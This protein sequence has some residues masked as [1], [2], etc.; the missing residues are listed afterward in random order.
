MKKFTLSKMKKLR[1]GKPVRFAVHFS[2]LM[3]AG[4]LMLSA[5]SF[6]QTHRYVK[7]GGTGDGSS[8]AEAANLAD[9]LEQAER[10]DVIHL[11]SGTHIPSKLI[12]GGDPEKPGDVTF[13]IAANISIVGGY[14]AEPEAGDEPDPATHASI[15]SGKLDNENHAVHVVTVTAPK[16][17]DHQVVISGIHI[18]DGFADAAASNVEVNGVNF[19]RDHGGGLIIGGASVVMTDCNI[20]NNRSGRM[21]A[22]MYVFGGSNLVMERCTIQNN[23]GVNTNSN[24]AGLFLN[25]TVAYLNNTYIIHN[26]AGGVAAGLQTFNGTEIYMT[27]S[28]I[29]Y[30]TSRTHGGGFYHRNN[31]TG[32]MINCL[33]YGNSNNGNGPG[34]CAHDNT[35]LDIISSTITNNSTTTNGGG[36]FTNAGTTFN[37]Y[38]S[39]V[40]GNIQGETSSDATGTGTFSFASSIR[41]EIV[42]DADQDTIP[43]LTFVPSEMLEKLSEYVVLPVGEDNPA[44]THG[45][46]VEELITLG[47]SLELD[48]EPAILA[49]DQLGNPREEFPYM[50]AFVDVVDETVYFYVKVDGAGNGSSWESPT[51]LTDALNRVN[52]G[53]VIHI[54]AGTYVPENTI[55]GGNPEDSGDITI[56]ISSNITMI[57]GYPANATEGAESDPEEHKT[58]LS[59]KLGEELHAYHVVTVT[60]PRLE[61]HKVV[62]E[63]IH[64]IEGFA[65][66]T[67]S[68]VEINGLN[69][70][71]DHG[72]GMLIGNAHIE[73]VNVTVEDNR[74]GRHAAGIYIFGESH[75]IMERCT[76]QNNV[77][78]NTTS[79]AAGMFMNNTVAHINETYF[80]YNEAGGVAAGLQT[81][82]GSE[83]YLTNS[84][85]ANNKSRT[86]G[87]GF[88]HR[89]N[90]VGYMINTLVYGNENNGNGPGLCS[91]DNTVL[92]IINSTITGNTTTT[93]GGGIFANPGTIFNIYN[94]IVSGN[95]QG[96][97]SADVAG[98]GTFNFMTAI[99]GGNVYD[100]E[101]SQISG[102][103][104][105]PGSML[106][107]TDD[108]VVMPVGENNPAISHGMSLQQL[109]ALG[110]EQAP[111]VSEA[112]IAY[113]Q[114]GNSRRGLDFM[115]AFVEERQAT[116]SRHYYV[117]VDGTGKG[118]SWEDAASL[119]EALER[120]FIAGDSI[121][122]AAGMYI[123]TLHIAGGDPSDQRD[124]TFHIAANIALI[125]G[126]PA[127]ANGDATA[128]PEEHATILSGEIEEDIHAYHVVVVSAAREDGQMVTLNG[129]RITKGYASDMVS[130]V[131]I[132]GFNFPRDHGGGILIGRARIDMIDCHVEE[133]RSGR[134]GAGMYV[135]ASANM[136]MERCMIKGN[137]GVNTTSNAA[138]LF[139][140]N[141][142]AFINHSFVID[143]NAGGVS[144]GIQTFNGSKIYMLNSVIANN[145]SRTHGGG[146]YH[147]NNS[148]G[149]MV[150][151][152][153][154]GNSNDGNGP[155]ICAHDNTVLDIISSTIV[156]NSTSTNGGGLFTNAGTTFNVYNS[157]VSGN[158][159]SES[160]SDAAGTGTFVFRHAVVGGDVFNNEGEQV[161]DLN[162]DPEEMLEKTDDFVVI[163]VGA[164]NPASTNG[165]SVSQL[166]TLGGSLDPAVDEAIMSA[167]QLGESREDTN[168]M[169][170]FIGDIPDDD[171]PNQI[172]TI[173][174]ENLVTFYPNP[175]TDNIHF[176]AERPV[177]RV[178][179][180]SLHGVMMI[181]QIVR[182]ATSVRVSSLAAGTYIVVVQTKDGSIDSRILI[183]Q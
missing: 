109:V 75:L 101:Q 147:R 8:W 106:E 55:T 134:H 120:A 21:A 175:F 3:F 167:D 143:N 128:D 151:C 116:E 77:G 6:G 140:D 70:P 30:N 127:N 93:N 7:P 40:S 51:T 74:S 164:D 107:K 68:S 90:S 162:F 124:K 95:T 60:A 141:A 123:P 138:G 32:Y 169:G 44:I 25:N 168:F 48:V 13:E 92:N 72:G 119:T 80:I 160:S 54:A 62:L 97:T 112:V 179:V 117:K 56:E 163:P 39:V 154:Y 43:D 91:H 81:F 2:V 79:N 88:Y 73:L 126:Y 130:N 46:T 5:T 28:V 38:N 170:A 173:K 172:R 98:T 10:G 61:E 183:K 64:I 20:D 49:A 129:L 121:H 65:D 104:F 110:A 9:A 96:E 158:T 36:L 139:L 4:L 18:K 159:Q 26:N 24:A 142:T 156:N 148:T 76:I 113:D 103:T 131:N 178:T 166:V 58:I 35:V 161:D 16:E 78:V 45:M 108:F 153:V 33:V 85:I 50:G 34:I 125:G 89:N 29:A 42:F 165:M 144:A 19:P 152:L 115:G 176:S 181:D 182:G 177:E 57:G 105:E 118:T 14:P 31:S 150:N 71:R 63:G 87:G 69:F 17:E 122:I 66:A 37:L 12:A 11:A 94:S 136:H 174:K 132:D 135:F 100:D 84:V 52:D 133:N 82:N 171:P 145:T 146:F 47:G 137:V 83:I 180:Y 23:V 157:I 1:T 102:L 41:G 67:A 27:N 15:L 22:G 53:G 59:G 149:Y 155:G 111:A 99:S 86:H 114:L